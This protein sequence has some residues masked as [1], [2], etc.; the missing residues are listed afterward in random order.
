MTTPK[1]QPSRLEERK[2]VEPEEQRT[3]KRKLSVFYRSFDLI[4]PIS[5][6]AEVRR[7]SSSPAVGDLEGSE[8][9]ARRESCESLENAGQRK[10]MENDENSGGKVR[11]ETLGKL[12]PLENASDLKS[13]KNTGQMESTGNTGERRSVENGG[14]AGPGVG[15]GNRESFGH[16]T[17]LQNFEG[18]WSG[19]SGNIVLKFGK[20]G[21][22]ENYEKLANAGRFGAAVRNPGNSEKTCAE[23]SGN[24]GVPV[25]CSRSAEVQKNYGRANESLTLAYLENPEIPGDPVTG[26]RS[27]CPVL[28]NWK[29]PGQSERGD[30]CPVKPEAEKRRGNISSA[31]SSSSS[32]EHEKYSKNNQHRSILRTQFPSFSLRYALLSK[33]GT[34]NEG[35]AGIPAFRHPDYRL[36]HIARHVP[37][38]EEESSSSCTATEEEKEEEEA[39]AEAGPER[40]SLENHLGEET[41][42]DGDGFP[43]RKQEN[44]AVSTEV[45]KPAQWPRVLKRSASEGTNLDAKGARFPGDGSGTR[46]KEEREQEEEGVVRIPAFPSLPA[47]RLQETG[48]INLPEADILYR[49]HLPEE[50]LERKYTAFS[51]GLGT[52]RITLSRRMGLAVHQR[53]LAERNLGSE[54]ERMK[55]DIHELWPLCTDRDSIEKVEKV[56]RRADMVARCGHRISCAAET[57]GATRQEHRISRAVLIADKYLQTLRTRC[58]IL[59]AELAETKRILLKNNI[60]LEENTNE[61]TD[62]LPRIRYRTTAPAN[63]RMDPPRQRNSVS[64]RMTIRRPSLCAESPRFETEKLHRT[65]S[66]SAGELR[67][68]SEQ[69]ESRKGSTEEN[70]NF[71]VLETHACEAEDSIGSNWAQLQGPGPGA[72]AGENESNRRKTK[73]PGFPGELS[74]WRPVLRSLG[75]FVV[76]FLANQ[77]ISGFGDD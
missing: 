34:G 36:P 17:K 62:D 44:D 27:K 19:G 75:I 11:L 48:L 41:T 57:V 59:A 7:S 64:G 15:S 22:L 69:T 73:E 31:S 54:L 32:P 45:K 33:D 13:V 14:K 43:E 49:E 4:G 16:L 51:I 50:E 10:K 35:P 28:R 26:L 6:H 24:P 37:R 39:E 5:D 56:Q 30:T 71:P 58:E 38:T 42:R 61:I 70:N 29:S 68:I 18:K 3:P 40:S 47:K 74:T 65:D 23:K 20:P 55:R 46:V 2:T 1:L 25:S 8:L 76:G 66:G 60:V 63:N 21:S 52:D 12:G 77:L 9:S 72:D 53:D 67:D